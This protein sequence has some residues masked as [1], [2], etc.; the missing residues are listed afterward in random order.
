MQGNAL[1]AACEEAGFSPRLS[2][3]VSSSLA[4]LN[5]VAAGLG[6]SVVPASLQRVSFEGVV[7]RRLRKPTQL[8]SPL[9]LISRRGDASAVVRQFL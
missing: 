8:K 7:Y 1:V 3:V 9:N 2:P 4:R 5:L 6:I